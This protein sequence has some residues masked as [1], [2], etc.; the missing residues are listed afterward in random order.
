MSGAFIQLPEI[1]LVWAIARSVGI[2]VSIGRVDR[3]NR[4]TVLDGWGEAVVVAAF[5]MVTALTADRTDHSGAGA[6]GPGDRGSCDHRPARP[7]RLHL[8]DT[9]RRVMLRS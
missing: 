2:V 4:G 5:L 8:S 9:E 6:H 7:A 1:L 3:G